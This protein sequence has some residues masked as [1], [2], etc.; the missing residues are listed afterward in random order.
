MPRNFPSQNHLLVCAACIIASMSTVSAMPEDDDCLHPGPQA[1]GVGLRPS[2]KSQAQ[3]DEAVKK[4]PTS[5]AVY[6]ER[7]NGYLGSSE[8][9]K[10]LADFNKALQL[11]PKCVRAYFG[12]YFVLSDGKSNAKALA[13]L[14]N[15]ERIGPPDLA[16]DAVFIAASLHYETQQFKESLAEFT[17]VINSKLL[18]KRRQAQAYLSRGVDY[19]RLGKMPEAIA[20][21]SEAIK[22]NRNL[23]EAYLYRANDL[24]RQNKLKEAIADYNYVA[25]R[26]ENIPEDKRI[27]EMDSVKEDLYRYRSD[28][29]KQINRPDLAK[30]DLKK[31]LRA[32]RENMEASPFQLK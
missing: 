32:E 20:D 3:M 13:E 23:G 7:G 10:A 30:A 1:I 2:H 24:R 21:F 27:F 14:K 15:V 29:F 31:L 8:N 6:L 26:V 28:Y 16:I 5:A 25:I 22:L 4:N 11:D 19:D 18:S 9:E 17:R 12:R